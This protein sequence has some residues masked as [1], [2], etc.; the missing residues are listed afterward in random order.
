[1]RLVPCAKKPPCKAAMRDDHKVMIEVEAVEL[2]RKRVPVKRLVQCLGAVKQDNHQ[3]GFFA[4]D[5]RRETRIQQ[6]KQMDHINMRECVE[7][8]RNVSIGRSV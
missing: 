7:R 8:T 4:G 1:M 3:I 5:S 6:G 2:P